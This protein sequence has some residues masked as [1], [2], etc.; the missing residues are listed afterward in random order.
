MYRVLCAL[1]AV[2]FCSFG[3][4]TQSIITDVVAGKLVNPQ[5]GQWAWYDLSDTV[6]GDK[7]FVRQ[8][9]VGEEKVNRKKGYWIELEVVPQV[10]FPT[11]YKMLVTGPAGKSRNVHRVFYKEG[12]KMAR[13]IPVDRNEPDIPVPKARRKSLGRE[14][15]ETGM[16]VIEADHFAMTSGDN[17]SEVWLNDAVMPMGVVRMA[18]S[19]GEL[20]LRSYGLGG[21]DGESKIRPGDEKSEP[22]ERIKV[23]V[24]IVNPNSAEKKG[25]K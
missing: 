6:S 11:I 3:A 2:V 22:V 17:T 24:D 1:L 10:G 23:E 9:I 13:E 18:T 19:D 15:V 12:D 25:T 20:L 14:K 16:G 4:S 5:V 8:A 7:F 21:E